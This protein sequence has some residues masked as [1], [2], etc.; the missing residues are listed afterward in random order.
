MYEVVKIIDTAILEGERYKETQDRYVDLGYSNL[1]WPNSKHNLTIQ[2]KIA[3]K[4]SQACDGGP[5]PIIWP[6]KITRPDTFV[7]DVGR[8]YVWVGVVRAVAYT[9]KIPIRCG[10][11]WNGN[12]EIADQTFDDLPHIELAR[13]WIAT[14]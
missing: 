1:R 8:W 14:P 4:K 5:Y 3:G 2:E 10:A 9:L 12:W 13:H 11:D 6:N 7:K